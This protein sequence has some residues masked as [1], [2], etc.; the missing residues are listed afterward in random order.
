MVSHP[1][2][3]GLSTDRP[4]PQIG[5]TV[6]HYA[7]MH[8]VVDVIDKLVRGGANVNATS[9]YEDVSATAPCEITHSYAP[10]W[11]AYATTRPPRT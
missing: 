1:R 2:R 6:L 5:L 8:G 11:R 10:Q 4:C 9:S 7:A 3:N